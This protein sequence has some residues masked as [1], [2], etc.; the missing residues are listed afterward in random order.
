[1]ETPIYDFV[2][3][4]ADSD[5]SRLHMP[6]HKGRGVLCEK[7]DIT[8]IKGADSLFEADGIIEQSEKNA[9]MLYKTA[10]TL[11]STGGSTLCIQTMI[12]LVSSFSN[13][14]EKPLIVAVRNAHKAFINACILLD[15]EVKWVFPDY[16]NSSMVSGEFSGRDIEKAIDECDRK[17]V[18]VYVTS[19]DYLGKVSD[20]ESIS[21]MCHKKGILLAVDNAHGAYLKFLE[22]DCHPITLG[23]DMCCDSA[24]KTLPVLTGGAYLHISENAPEIFRKIA[25]DTMSLFASTSPSYLIMT[26][27]DLCNRYIYEKIRDDLKDIVSKIVN[28]KNKLSDNGFTICK[29][30]PLKLTVNTTTTGLYGYEVAEYMREQKIECE[31]SDSMYIVFMFTAFNSQSD[32]DKLYNAFMSLKKSDKKLIFPQFQPS[33]LKTAMSIRKAA[34][35]SS[36]IIDTDNSLGRICAKVTVACPPGIPVTVSGEVINTQAI[37]ILKNYGINKVNVVK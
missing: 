36:E 27:L 5:I 3:E 37:K 21:K 28:L 30:D 1:M 26:S 11:Y 6:G 7:Y 2:T 24:H 14:E 17:P 32:F 20:I 12:A 10:K 25:K 15:C 23:A 18:A 9:S 31:Y 29:S 4:Y 16:S 34:L 19:P 13:S 8:E 33:E 22:N 35:S